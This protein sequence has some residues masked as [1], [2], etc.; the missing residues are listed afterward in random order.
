MAECPPQAIER[1]PTNFLSSPHELFERLRLEG[2]VRHVVMPHGAAVWMVTRYDDVRALLNDPRVSKDGR[3]MSEMY[4]RHSGAVVGDGEAVEPGF[5]DNLSLHMLNSDPPLHTRLRAQVSKAFTLSSMRRLR[6]RIEQVTDELLDAMDGK[7]EVDLVEALAIP[8]PLIMICELHGIPPEDRDSWQR[9]ST[10]LVGSGHPPAE[11]TEA[12]GRVTEYVH[13]L[14][15][16]RRASPGDDLVSEMVRIMDSDSGQL[17]RDELTAMVFVLVAA[18]LDTPMRQ[19][20]VA[21][22]NLL[23]HPEELAKLRADPSMI[24]AAVDELM[25]FDGTVATSSFRFAIDDIQVGDVTIPAGEMVLLSLASANRDSAHFDDPGRLDLGRRQLGNLAFGHG[26][27]Y[28]IGAHLA[29]QEMEIALARLITRFP[30]LRLAV[31]P[32]ELRWED[33]NLLRCLE[34]LPVLLG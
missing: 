22:Y 32:D 18:G 16:I 3:R 15:E 30:N 19:I 26:P 17:S 21:V 24:S 4:V 5:D 29:K 14:I 13:R 11:V 12:S 28:C 7:T 6:P 2:P 1:I 8:L 27:H 33:G 31:K 34:E 9:W 23:T 10:R 20:G 25:R